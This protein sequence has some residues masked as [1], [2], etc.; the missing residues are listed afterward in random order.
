MLAPMVEPE[1]ALP[2]PCSLVEA[3]EEDGLAAWLATLPATIGRLTAAWSL[4]VGAPFQP[5]G[6]TAWVAPVRDAAGAELV[7]KVAWRHPEAEHEA[8]GLRVWAGQGAVRLFAAETA[9]DTT[10]LLLEHCVPGTAL[11]TRPEGDQDLVVADLLGRLWRAPPAGHGFRP[12]QVMCDQWADEFEAKVAVAGGAS[13][14]GLARDGIALFRSL[15]A[16]AGRQVMLCTDLHAENIL[17]AAR[18]PWLA[19]DPKPYV[20]DPTYDP[21]QHMLNCSE[22]LHADPRALAA[23][24]ADLLDLDRD[25]LLLWLFARCV[26]ES[27]DDQPLADIA[28]RIAPN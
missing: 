8:A 1:P 20:G 13:D 2:L 7:L 23:R 27:P 12:L 25:R 6:Q 14:P 28:R 5:G 15:P 4:T 26:Q 9:G 16:S 18:E 11:A 19:I 3:A 21:L 17:A 10:A 22:R 24:M